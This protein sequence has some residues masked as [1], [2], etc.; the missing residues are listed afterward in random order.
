MAATQTRGL[1]IAIIDRGR[2]VRVRS[3]GARNAAGA[4][5]RTDTIMYGAS[6]TKTAFAAMVMQHVDAGRLDLDQPLATYLDRPLPDY[7]D[8]D[9]YA[10]WSDLAGDDRWQQITA[11][12]VLTHSAGFANFAFLEPDGKLHARCQFCAREYL[13]DPA[14]VGA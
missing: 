10:P 6:L 8:E 4:P 2:V 13:I 14:N 9:R 1:A 7:P 12:H 3:Y 11:R 5:L